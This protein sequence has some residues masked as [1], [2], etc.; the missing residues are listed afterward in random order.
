MLN[1]A[2]GSDLSIIKRKNQEHL[3]MQHQLQVQQI[4]QQHHLNS[5]GQTNSMTNK[6]QNILS[7]AANNQVK[8]FQIQQ[9]LINQQHLKQIKLQQQQQQRHQLMFQQQQQQQPQTQLNIQ[10]NSSSNILA[11]LNQNSTSSNENLAG[12]GQNLV[13]IET[14]IQ[15]TYNF[16]VQMLKERK[17]YLVKELNTIIQYALLNNQQNINKQLKL[18]YQL[19]MKKQQL[20][21]E[22]EQELNELKQ[23]TQQQ[24]QQQ[25]QHNSPMQSP[26]LNGKTSMTASAKAN[27][28]ENSSTSS[29][30][31]SLSPNSTS[32]TSSPHSSPSNGDDQLIGNNT[33]INNNEDINNVNVTALT[34]SILTQ[35]L[36]NKLNGLTELNNLLLLNNQLIN[37]LK[38]TNPLQSIEFLS[39]FSAIQTS[40]RNT[41]GYIR[42]NQQQQQHQQQT[43]Q[44]NQYQNGQNVTNE[45]SII[46]D[47][48]QQQ[49]Q[50]QHPASNQYGKLNSGSYLQQNQQQ[51]MINTLSN[52]S[53]KSNSTSI[54]SMSTASG[55]NSGLPSSSSSSSTSGGAS[56]IYSNEF[57]T[58]PISIMKNVSRSSVNINNNNNINNDTIID[59]MAYEINNNDDLSIN[60]NNNNTNSNKIKSL[61]SNINQNDLK[62]S[63]TWSSY[64][65]AN[66][67]DLINTTSPDTSHL[68]QCN[69]GLLSIGGANVN[70]SS[71]NNNDDLYSTSL[72]SQL[73]N[74]NIISLSAGSN[75]SNKSNA[76]SKSSKSSTSHSLTNLS[77]YQTQNLDID[78]YANANANNNNNNASSSLMDHQYSFQQSKILSNSNSSSSG[79]NINTNNGNV[80][81]N[82]NINT[83]N[84]SSPQL[85][86]SKMIYHCK[87]GE[88][89]INDGQF[90]E[91][92][93]VTINTNNDI[94]VADTNSHRIQ[95]FDKDGRFKFKF[96]ECGKR[97]GQLLY[98]NRVSIVK[99][100]GDIVV[101]ERSPTHQ[102]QIYNK[103]GQFLRKF[104]ANILQHPRGVC[105]DYKGRIVVVECKVMRV[106]IFDLY[107][108]VLQKFNCSKYLEFPN[109]VCCSNPN[110]NPSM[111]TQEEIYISDN[112]AHCIKVFDYN[113]NFI[114]QIGC[115]GITNYPIGVGINSN[116]EILVADNHNNFNLTV[117]SQDGQLINALE[118]K[119]KH[120]QCFDVGLMDDGSIVLASKDYRIYVYK[121]VASSP[122]SAALT[123]L[124]S[125]SSNLV[126]TSMLTSPNNAALSLLQPSLLTASSLS[127]N[128]DPV[129]AAAVAQ[130]GLFN[131]FS[132]SVSS[133][134]TS[135]NIDQNLSKCS[136]NDDQ[137]I[138]DNFEI[139]LDDNSV[140]P[141]NFLTANFLDKYDNSG[142]AFNLTNTNDLF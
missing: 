68:N 26:S 69:N 75:T 107:G 73:H 117:F 134:G 86:R 142:L 33:N 5:A 78:I 136:N 35:N 56:N 97:D 38:N 138:I 63:S 53:T 92:S 113:G 140:D 121:Y 10:N 46:C 129:T 79:L 14:E 115:E 12:N 83:N 131:L 18:Q 124:G 84:N 19:E 130:S 32:S 119:V 122:A 127:N 7:S 22:T 11:N 74:K 108:N 25:Q 88:F 102:I 2:N 39:N 112:R 24:Q 123:T 61:F 34:V 125:T 16:Y 94:I 65:N 139:N 137:N 95:I 141:V 116:N 13:Q 8:Q 27:G 118:S 52:N 87:F 4:Q 15:K 72:S 47:M 100:T 64:L 21:K 60:H 9:Q 104:G 29:A 67:D 135:A 20:E 42:I 98:P 55:C 128:F 80:T 57:I 45:L 81:S 59:N 71:N 30:S 126:Q 76:S 23:L 17:D 54:S 132:N 110:N 103:Y 40:I 31:S 37:Q 1:A 99:Q 133:S 96:G 82:G 43:S 90:T 3:Q 49:Q 89:G 109:G 66:E 58:S 41:F 111:N 70:S 6:Q 51:L 106:L 50:Q 44:S 120:A 114:R 91:P 48:K 101:T 77:A 28:L 93:G 105:V 62:S 36:N 85:I